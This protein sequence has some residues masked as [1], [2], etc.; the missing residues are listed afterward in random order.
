[1]KAKINVLAS[2][3]IFVAISDSCEVCKSWKTLSN[4]FIFYLLLSTRS[5][6]VCWRLFVKESNFAFMKNWRIEGFHFHLQPQYKYELFHVNFHQFLKDS[7]DRINLKI[8][9]SQSYK[10]RS[11]NLREKSTFNWWLQG[12]VLFPRDP[13]LF[14]TEGIVGTKIHCF[15]SL[16]VLFYLPTQ[17]WRKLRKK[18]LEFVHD[19]IT[20]ESNAQAF[21]SLGN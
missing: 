15:P 2:C 21:V 16:S 7:F 18:L 14:N 9:N 1:M 5:S 13:Q 17:K 3:L 12:R 10:F 6:I 8:R 11:K 20:C 4:Y 19:L